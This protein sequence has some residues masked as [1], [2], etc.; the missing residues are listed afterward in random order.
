[1][2]PLTSCC[3][4]T[5]YDDVSDIFLS[6]YMPATS[7][8][9]TYCLYPYTVCTIRLW[10]NVPAYQNKNSH[11]PSTAGTTVNTGFFT[12]GTYIKK[13]SKHLPMY[14]HDIIY[15]KN[16]FL[17]TLF[18]YFIQI[19]IKFLFYFISYL[20]HFDKVFQLPQKKHIPINY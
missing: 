12:Y 17:F 16:I 14:K 20:S 2:H 6:P 18:T 5:L 10:V 1:M 4:F 9:W 7:Y 19:I 3:L 11:L 15:E 8:V 13:F